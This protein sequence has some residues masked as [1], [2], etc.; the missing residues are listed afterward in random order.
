[1]TALGRE[2]AANTASVY[3]VDTDNQ[4]I[5]VAKDVDFD[6]FVEFSDIRHIR[7]FPQKSIIISRTAAG[8]AAADPKALAVVIEWILTSDA[9]NPKPLT[10]KVLES[11][12]FGFV[13]DIHRATYALRVRRGKRHDDIHDAL[14][15]YTR[16]G[17]LRVDEFA[18][19][20]E[21]LSFDTSLTECAMNNVMLS[22]I[23][24][25]KH[26]NPDFAKIEQYARQM[27]LWQTMLEAETRI[28][29]KHEQRDGQ[30]SKE[31]KE[32]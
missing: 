11:D 19:I 20:F 3:L 10:T 1:M 18:L 9:A 31:A 25:G 29:A 17:H 30:R 24:G 15:E 21:L 26:V 4:L 14:Y 7:N 12:E 32:A 13:A 6:R 23:K 2:K 8:F 28:K 27:G 16:E 5:E 22:K